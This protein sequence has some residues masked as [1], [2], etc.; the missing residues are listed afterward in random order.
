MS[1]RINHANIVSLEETFETSTKLY[2]VMTL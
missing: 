2:L 1:I